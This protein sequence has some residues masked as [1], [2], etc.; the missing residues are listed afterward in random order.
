MFGGNPESTA[1]SLT[2]R[3][4]FPDGHKFDPTAPTPLFPF[5]VTD[6][7]LGAPRSQTG[8][9]NMFGGASVN[10]A[11]FRQHSIAI[12]AYESEIFSATSGSAVQILIRNAAHSMGYLQPIA[13]PMFSDSAST[14]SVA[15]GEAAM[16]RSLYIRRRIFHLLHS[17]LIG[18]VKL[19]Q[20]DGKSNFADPLTKCVTKQS[21]MWAVG[22]WMGLRNNR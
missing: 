11:A 3:Q 2:Q 10:T 14:I 22:Y 18:E 16:R 7:A 6:G 9:I 5:T 1:L 17:V 20:V 15:E 19:Y 13:A 4:Q 12:N 8:V 21:Y